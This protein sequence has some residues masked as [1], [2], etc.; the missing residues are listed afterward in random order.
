M[1]KDHLKFA[2]NKHK[3]FRFGRFRVV[4]VFFLVEQ[5][6]FLPESNQRASEIR[7]QYRGCD[8]DTASKPRQCLLLLKKKKLH[9]QLETETGN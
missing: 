4:W 8:R 6:F 7:Q 1:T 5:V 9:S 3:Y 2:F